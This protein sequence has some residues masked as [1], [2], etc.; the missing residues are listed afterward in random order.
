[1]VERTLM[2]RIRKQVEENNIEYIQLRPFVGNEAEFMR[3]LFE[4]DE[5]VKEFY[6]TNK[7]IVDFRTW[8][9]EITQDPSQAYFIIQSEESN[10]GFIK[11]S[12]LND[13]KKSYKIGVVV[14]ESYRRC[15]I[16]RFAVENIMQIMNTFGYNQ[17]FAHILKINMD[18]INFFTN[19]GFTEI[20]IDGDYVVY[21]H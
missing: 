2:G 7:T 18:S 12:E 15:G 4:E 13:I 9:N 16:G 10:I 3:Q 1:M 8:I 17:V 14:S 20:G 21:R 19:L 11:V 6:Y 5:K